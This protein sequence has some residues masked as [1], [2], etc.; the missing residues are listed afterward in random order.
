[1]FELEAQGRCLFLGKEELELQVRPLRASP[2]PAAYQPWAWGSVPVLF[3]PGPGRVK[4]VD[5]G[6]FTWH[7]AGALESRLG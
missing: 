4:P 5:A 6:G 2:C 1:M 3:P 7:G